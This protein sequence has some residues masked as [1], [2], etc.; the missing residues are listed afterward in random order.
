MSTA[1]MPENLK[2]LKKRDAREYVVQESL[3]L[4]DS[5]RIAFN[6]GFDA[7]WS[8]L[9]PVIEEMQK[10]LKRIQ[11]QGTFQHFCIN[12]D[13]GCNCGSDKLE[14]AICQAL[15]KVREVLDE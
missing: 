6:K 11:E 13:Q 10:T 2:E 7:C 3:H 5:E 12:G 4:D 1:K 14:I 15:A 9:A 8:H